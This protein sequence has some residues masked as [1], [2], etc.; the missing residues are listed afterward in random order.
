[1]TNQSLEESQFRCANPALNAMQSLVAVKRA[2]QWK[3]A[4]FQNTPAA[5]HGR[6]EAVVQLTEELRKLL[7][8]GDQDDR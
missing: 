1:M 2:N 8:K 4:L 3:V 5:F 6:P 7:A